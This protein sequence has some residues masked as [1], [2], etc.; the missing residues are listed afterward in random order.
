M[1]SN[2]WND[3]DVMIEDALRSEPLRE[4]PAGFHRR[5]DERLRIVAMVAKERK[6]FQIRVL[7]STAL[8]AALLFTVVVVP[9]LAY[10]QGWTVRSMPGA[11]GYLDYLA[12]FVVQEWEKLALVAVG[13]ALVAAVA[14]GLRAAVSLVRG[15]AARQH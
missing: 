9:A 6:G 2:E 12:V 13:V 10:A 1:L 11:M 3:L 8:F 4:A 14:L 5:L 15:R 7:A